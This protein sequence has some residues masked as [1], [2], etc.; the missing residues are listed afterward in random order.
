MELLRD[1]MRDI[2]DINRRI[3]NSVR[4]GTVTAVDP[5]TGTAKVSFGGDTESAWLPVSSFR[6]GGARV[7]APTVVGEQ[8]MVVSPSGDTTQGV[9][10]GSIP[11]NAFPSPSSD[12]DEGLRIEMG[13]ATISVRADEVVISCGGSTIT[14]NAGGIALNGARID[15]N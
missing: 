9:I 6:A 5:S 2:A 8:V 11:S 12:G 15:L 14:L 1:M 4:Y 7:W 3:A 10:S 13:A